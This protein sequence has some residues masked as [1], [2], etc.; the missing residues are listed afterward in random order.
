MIVHVTCM[1]DRFNLSRVGDHFI[2]D[3][4]FGE[5][6]SAWLVAQLSAR[7][8]K[9]DVLC[10]EDFGWANVAEHE[11]VSYSVCV[12]GSPDEDAARPDFGEWHVMLE[13]HRTLVQR[14]LGK[15][16]MFA[17]DPLVGKVLEI[18]R[19]AGFEQVAVEP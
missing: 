18:P 13:R 2:N 16:A 6:F 17:A 9:A 8:V 12:A 7:G 15:N 11:G 3:C 4:C 5:D 10:Q 19:S 14:I 1:T